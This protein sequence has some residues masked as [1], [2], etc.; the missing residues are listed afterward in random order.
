MADMSLH[1]VRRA[2]DAEELSSAMTYL[3]EEALCENCDEIVG[4]DSG[5]FISC[6]VCVDHDSQDLW[7]VCMSCAESV[8]SPG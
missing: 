4:F 8:I 3:L 1:I 2:A 6:V 7:T 5:R